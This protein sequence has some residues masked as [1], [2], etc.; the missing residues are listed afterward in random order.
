MRL[1][2]S[3]PSTGYAFRLAS[4]SLDKPLGRAL[5]GAERKRRHDR[6][7]RDGLTHARADLPRD[8]GE[9]LIDRGFIVDPRS[10]D[11]DEWGASVVE[12]LQW[13]MQIDPE[14]R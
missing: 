8:V 12:A 5:T 13:A 10:T 9:W 7:V 3:S 6:R 1:S 2:A 4:D 11:P 14:N